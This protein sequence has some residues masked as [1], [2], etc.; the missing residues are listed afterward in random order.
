[1]TSPSPLLFNTY[2]H[3][4]NRGTNGGNIFIQERNYDY[5][6]KLY[7]R[8]IAP[9]ADTFAYCMLRNHFHVSI[10][11]KSEEEILPVIK[12][13]QRVSSKPFGSDKLVS[14]Y[15]SDQFSNYFNAYAKTINKAYGRTGS[16]FQHPF[17]RVPITTDRQFWN[18]IAYIHQNPQKHG[19]VKDF[20]DWK[21][22]SY[23]IILNEKLTVINR[24]E[25]MR[26]F[27]TKDEYLSLHSEWV[28]DA[29]A[30]WFAEDDND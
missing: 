14:Q 19:F 12:K 21:Y 8:H 30:K 27:G 22:S 7:E 3:I 23:G 18:V 6:L 5:F 1:M 29:Q 17:G 16:L 24:G 11:T 20:R 9:V 15:V 25:V 4:Y 26:W 2:Y 10:K 28:T 13:T